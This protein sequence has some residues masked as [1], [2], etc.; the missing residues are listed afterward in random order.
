MHS[1]MYGVLLNLALLTPVKG[2]AGEKLMMRKEVEG[3]AA[4]TMDVDMIQ[5]VA[6]QSSSKSQLRPIPDASKNECTTGNQHAHF[7]DS[8]TVSSGT[9]SGQSVRWCEQ[10]CVPNLVCA[11]GKT[12]P[13]DPST[14]CSGCESA[15]GSPCLA[16]ATYDCGCCDYSGGRLRRNTCASENAPDNTPYNTQCGSALRTYMYRAS[17]TGEPPC[18]L[19]ECTTSNTLSTDANCNPQYKMAGGTC[20]NVCTGAYPAGIDSLGYSDG[21]CTSVNPGYTIVGLMD[22]TLWF[23]S[24]QIS[25]MKELHNNATSD[26]TAS[27]GTN[28]ANSD[29]ASPPSSR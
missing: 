14:D 2:L 17:G 27:A 19:D 18:T 9:Y 15:S 16:D 28:W 12:C 1:S 13:A 11:P 21:L 24:G 29:C 20:F 7:I 4:S 22:I 23:T 10:A 6:E 26:G 3:A 8:L 5:M 25:L